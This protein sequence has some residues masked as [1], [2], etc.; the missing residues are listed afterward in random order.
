MK[1]KNQFD[2]LKTRSLKDD[3][4]KFREKIQNSNDKQTKYKYHKLLCQGFET[5]MKIFDLKNVGTNEAYLSKFNI[6][7]TYL[8]KEYGVILSYGNLVDEE[9]INN[10][11]KNLFTYV[12]VLIQLSRVSVYEF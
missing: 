12:T 10:I 9:V 4:I 8:V 5:F 7:L 6:Y 3:M 11:K 2:L 1:K